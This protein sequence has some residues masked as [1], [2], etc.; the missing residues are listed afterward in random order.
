MKNENQSVSLSMS[1]SFGGQPADDREYIGGKRRINGDGS[2]TH[3]SFYD[4]GDIEI[5]TFNDKPHA[6]PLVR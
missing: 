4:N 2:V 3:I 6:E 5:N 1:L